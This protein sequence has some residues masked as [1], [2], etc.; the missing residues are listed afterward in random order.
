MP[1]LTPH[2]RTRSK[3]RSIRKK[4]KKKVESADDVIDYQFIASKYP[5]IPL[6]LVL[7][8]EKEFLRADVD[9]NGEID[10]AGQCLYTYLRVHCCWAN[11]K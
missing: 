4:G 8:A 7:K 5:D 11:M 9:G 3:T 1:A 10:L 2:N 6:G